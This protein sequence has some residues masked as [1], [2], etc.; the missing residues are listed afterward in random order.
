MDSIQLVGV[1][2]SI[3]LASRAMFS[4][5]RFIDSMSQLVKVHVKQL[6]A[7]MTSVDRINSSKARYFLSHS[8]CRCKL[9]RQSIDL[10]RDERLDEYTGAVYERCLASVRSHSEY[11]K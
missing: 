10:A 3:D 2:H 4:D 6:I 8:I 11:Q 5:I 7:A 9:R 1:K